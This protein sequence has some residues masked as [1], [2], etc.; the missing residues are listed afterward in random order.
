LDKEQQTDSNLKMQSHKHERVESTKELQR[1]TPD[2]A[3]DWALFLDVDGTLLEIADHP[4][5]V[6]I[7]PELIATLQ[8]V[9]TAAQ[10]PIGLVSGRT[11]AD[12]DRLFAPLRLPT[13]GQHGAERRDAA[14]KMHRDV[15]R[16]AALD[17][18][19]HAL[20]AFNRRHAGI[21]LEDKGAALAIHFRQAP[22][23]AGEVETLTR[24][25]MKKL[26]TDYELQPG[27]MVVEIKPRGRNKGHAV[28]EFIREPPFAGR[29]PVFIGDD[30]TDEYGFEMVNRLGGHSVKVG[31]GT[32]CARWRLRNV[33]DVIDWLRGYAAGRRPDTGEGQ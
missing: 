7:R 11:I 10:T 31:T 27:K 13:A 2:Y 32:S 33:T 4:Q 23:L 5:D 12:L 29:L 17:D 22:N 1:R 14:G 25:L 3:Y 19:R 26:G 28:A 8:S 21:L 9:L 15:Q 30:A 20:E 18:A 24:E 6:E 16:N